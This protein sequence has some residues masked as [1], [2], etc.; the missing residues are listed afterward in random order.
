MNALLDT[1]QRAHSSSRQIHRPKHDLVDRRF[2]RLVAESYV[3]DG[4]WKCR[5][6]CG[7]RKAIKGVHLRRGTTKSCG[8]MKHGPAAHKSTI[9]IRKKIANCEVHNVEIFDSSYLRKVRGLL[10]R[11]RYHKMSEHG[12]DLND[13]VFRIFVYRD[14]LYVVRVK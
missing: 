2:S 8:C 3:G 5:C 11:A 14:T 12:P 1:I 13:K 6:D 9:A 10:E 4:R 7:R